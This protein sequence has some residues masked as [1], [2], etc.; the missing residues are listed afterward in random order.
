MAGKTR[1]LCVCAVLICMALT[2]LYS[3]ERRSYVILPL[4]A[5]P[6]PLLKDGKPAELTQDDLEK[7]D[8]LLRKYIDNYNRNTREA[9]ESLIRIKQHPGSGGDQTLLAILN[10]LTGADIELYLISIDM[11]KRQ[12]IA[13]INSRGEKEVWINCFRDPEIDYW[14]YSVVTVYGGGNAFFNLMINLT[15]GDLHDFWVNGI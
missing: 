5:A 10:R 6:H 8:L 7:I 12:Y 13:I 9:V 3:Q 2:N 14:E 15:T 1:S 4:E 11:Y